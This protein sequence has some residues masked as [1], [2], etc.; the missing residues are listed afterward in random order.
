MGRAKIKIIVE[1]CIELKQVFS[2]ERTSKMKLSIQ[3]LFLF[4]YYFLSL[5]AFLGIIMFVRSVE[6]TFLAIACSVIWLSTTACVEN[7][8]NMHGNFFFM[9]SQAKL[10]Y[11]NV[12]SLYVSAT[13]CLLG[14]KG[15]EWREWDGLCD[16]HPYL[17]MILS[18]HIP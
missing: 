13:L 2:V 16:R 3:F 7:Y 17:L 12:L 15:G 9:V 8:L 4:Y 6:T 11:V 5:G 10:I 18:L 14:Q 1:F